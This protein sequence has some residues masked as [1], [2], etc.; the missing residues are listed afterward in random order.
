[1]AWQDVAR[2]GLARR[3]SQR[4]NQIN[5]RNDE[6]AR[7]PTVRR[8][9]EATKR[10]GGAGLGM[11]WRGAARQGEGAN[12]STKSTGATM[13]WRGMARQG[14][15]GPGSARQGPQRGKQVTEE[16]A[17]HGSA[18]HGM[19][20]LGLARYGRGPDGAHLQGGIRW[21]IGSN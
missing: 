2:R 21:S 19:P 5:R 8:D 1:M 10:L 15:A 9:S 18:G 4:L 12:G 13:S 20:R 17:G 14:T 6:P 3:G 16:A 11:A 7:G